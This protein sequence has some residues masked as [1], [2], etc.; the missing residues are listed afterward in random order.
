MDEYGK[1]L[2]NAGRYPV[3]TEAEM[4]VHTRHIRAW[5]DEGKNEKAGRRSAQ[6]MVRHNLRLIPT[7]FKK[8][9]GWMDKEDHRITDMLQEGVIGLTRGVMKY[10]HTRGYKFSTY[11]WNW[12]RQGMGDYLRNRGRMIR[13]AASCSDKVMQAQRY[14][15]KVQSDTGRYPSVEELAEVCQLPLK[16]MAFYLERWTSTN[17]RSLN[18][19]VKGMDNEECELIDTIRSTPYDT[20][21]IARDEARQKAV[22]DLLHAANLTDKEMLLI[23]HR[24]LSGRNH[25]SLKAIGKLP[26]INMSCEGVRG[27]ER[28]LMNRLRMHANHGA[29]CPFAV[30]LCDS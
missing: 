15:S 8:Q 20:D 12:I 7:V 18:H 14:A 19:F 22:L 27:I 6:I 3:L 26:E 30:E 25:L 9:F 17:A 11:A 10:E 1:W 5:Q 29:C 28:K 24:Y 2:E 16:T 21:S 4:I 13:V 23:Q